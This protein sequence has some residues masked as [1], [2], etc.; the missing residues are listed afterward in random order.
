MSALKGTEMPTASSPVPEILEQTI[1]RFWE[2]VPPLWGQIRGHIREVATKGF[3]ITVEQFHILRYIRR[4]RWS[5]SKLAEAKNISRSA[6][7]QGVDMLVNKGLVTRTKN[8]DDRRYVQLELTKAGN[9]LLDA[10]I[11]D[12][13]AWMQIRL[14]ALSR[15]EL[16]NVIRAME[17]LKKMVE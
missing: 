1:D 7:S 3:D 8:P 14:T 2:T 16:E 17:S 15:S 6:I 12:T 13:R 9:D 4:G 10:V 11:Q 5:V